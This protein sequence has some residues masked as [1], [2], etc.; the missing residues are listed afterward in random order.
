MSVETTETNIV[1]KSAEEPKKEPSYFEGKLIALIGI[2]LLT[3]FLTIISLG[4]A[5]PAMYCMKKRWIYRNTVVGGYRLKFTG[6]GR[7][8]IGKYILW[9]FLSIIT[10]GIFTLWLPIKYQKWE[11]KHVE[12]DCKVEK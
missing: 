10:I 1:A 5:Y 8:L 12:I 11:T 9:S 3:F 6:K 2:N 4:F 7:Q